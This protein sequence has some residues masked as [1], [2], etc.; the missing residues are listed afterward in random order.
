MP[1]VES[2]LGGGERG[3]GQ[4]RHPWWGV[5]EAALS[6]PLPLTQNKQTLL[7]LLREETSSFIFPCHPAVQRP[8]L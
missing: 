1:G 7:P 2:R 5:S 3:A 8:E 4:P 6:H